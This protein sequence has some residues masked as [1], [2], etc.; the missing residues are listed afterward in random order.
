MAASVVA[1]DVVE[2]LF[3]LDPVAA[4]LRDGGAGPDGA[5]LLFARLLRDAF[6]LAACG[7]YRPFRDLA[8]AAVAATLPASTDAQRFAVASAFTKLPAHP[9]AEPALRRLTDAGVRV[10]TLTNGSAATTA[11]LLDGAGLDRYVE[12]VISV[13]EVR[14]WKPAPA[15]YRHAAAVLAVE[16]ASLVMVSV[17]AWDVHGARLAGLR[18][19]WA[20]RL[21]GRFPACFT[22]P[23]IE[24]AD[25][26][27]VAE[28]LVSVR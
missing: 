8:D 16:A 7:G 21:E 23:D 27:E 17:H 15:P 5:R 6:A 20:A 18:T 10:V 1:F 19:A 13:D 3:S 22:P 12:R 4:A 14:Q 28:A 9:D 24:G 2:T 25:L 26:I 11:S